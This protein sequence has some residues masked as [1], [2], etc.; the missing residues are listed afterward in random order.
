MKN[1]CVRCGGEA[2]HWDIVC[3]DC[4]RKEERNGFI[5]AIVVI[6]LLFALIVGVR[7]AWAMY[8]F[9][10]W[11]CALSECRIIKD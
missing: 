8:A 2:S 4:K 7:V 10:D 5:F 1:K 9:D 6:G 11:R 3:Y